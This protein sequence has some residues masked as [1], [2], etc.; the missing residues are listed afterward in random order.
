MAITPSTSSGVE[1]LEVQP[2]GGVEVRGDGL[3][4]VVNHH[5]VVARLLEHPHA[6]H[7]GIVELD[8]LADA[9]GAGAQHDYAGLLFLFLL[10]EFLGLVFLIV[11]GIEIRRLR[12]KLS[13]AGVHHFVHRIPVRR[14]R[15]CPLKRR[16][17][18]SG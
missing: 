4:V 12:L 10:Q 5:H 17:A 14:R 7:G 11:G 6:M 9:D 16:M 1:R 3:G 15:S 2:V 8:A 18:L 13:R